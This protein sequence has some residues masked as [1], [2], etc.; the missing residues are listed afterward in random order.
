MVYKIRVDKNFSCQLV[1]LLTRQLK[2]QLAK[3]ELYNKTSNLE[4]YK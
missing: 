2:I 1:F 4:H 3:L